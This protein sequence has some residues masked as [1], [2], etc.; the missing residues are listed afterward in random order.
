MGGS[1]NSASMTTTDLDGNNRTYNT[2]TDYGCYEYGSSPQARKGRTFSANKDFQISVYPNPAS[3]FLIINTSTEQNIAISI[4]NVSGQRVYLSE[5]TSVN[6]E[7]KIS[8]SDFNPGVYIIK[9]QSQNNSIS[10]RII[11]Q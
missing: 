3:D 6:G 9:L 10:K 7:E 11:I 5:N 8:L 2:K 1:V 4:Y